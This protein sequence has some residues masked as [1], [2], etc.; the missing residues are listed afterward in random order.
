[1]KV[2]MEVKIDLLR[3][4]HL[5]APTTG[6]PTLHAK[7]RAQRRL[8]RCKYR[9]LTNV[10]QTLHQPDRCNGLAFTGDRRSRCCYQHQ[11]SAAAESRVFEQVQTQLRTERAAL[12]IE[13]F[14]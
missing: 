7:H 12:L 5:R 6:R 3:R 11:V 1:M 4:F 9:A 14:C 13:V 2:T 8:A 10:L